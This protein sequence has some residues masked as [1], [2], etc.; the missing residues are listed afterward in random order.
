MQTWKFSIKPD[1]RPGFDAFNKCK[2]LGVVGIGWSHVYEK[3]QPKDYEQAKEIWDI[4]QNREINKLFFEIQD[5][6]HLWIH[7][8]GHYYLCVAGNVRYIAREI[9]DD[10]M[11][12]DLGHAIKVKWINVPEGLVTGTIQRGVIAQ[13]M[14]QRIRLNESEMKLSKYL[15]ENIVDGCLEFPL[16]TNGD[17]AEKLNLIGER[18]F[19][20]MSPDDIED[21][22]S[23]SLQTN[24]WILIKSTCFRSK[25]K[26]EFS[27]IN[28]VGKIGLVQVKSGHWPDSLVPTGYKQYLSGENEIFL[29]TTNPQAYPGD[30]VENIHCIEKKQ[31]LDWMKNNSSI[32]SP[33]LKLKLLII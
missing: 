11:N 4:G 10:F 25:P 20:L 3:D 6:D 5:G 28:K 24:G 13:R 23:A 21:V 31:L 7:K 18:I 22:V 15:Q 32:L 17:L 33:A 29:F 1:S 27:M 30:R 9:C 12:Y 8:N 14:I 16:I 26:F 2:E 19:Q